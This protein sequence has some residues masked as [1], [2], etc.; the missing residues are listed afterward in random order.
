MTGWAQVHGLRGEI[1]TPEKAR[2][3]VAY[4]LWYIDHWSF[5]LDIK[6]LFMTVRVILSRQNAY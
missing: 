1:D 3:R 2:A 5:W 6:I 4:D